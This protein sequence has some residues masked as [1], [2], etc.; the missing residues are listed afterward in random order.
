MESQRLRCF[1][2]IHTALADTVMEPLRLSLELEHAAFCTS[3]G[4]FNY[5]LTVLRVLQLIKEDRFRALL[6][7]DLA[8]LELLALPSA[9]LYDRIP[10][11]EKIQQEMTD[12]ETGQALLR[13]LNSTELMDVPD[14]GVRCGKCGGNDIT[15][16]FLQT[17]SADEGTTVYCN[18]SVCQK[19][20]RM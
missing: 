6:S 14:A 16:E 5:G 18:C 17:R 9:S 8:A 7:D 3:Q 13:D 10:C 12:R 20:W 2:S 19:R 11:R 1:R 4:A 15:F